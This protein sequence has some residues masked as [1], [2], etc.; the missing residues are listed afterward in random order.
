MAN[1]FG[2]SI[3]DGRAYA[4]HNAQPAHDLSP[5]NSA[6]HLCPIPKAHAMQVVAGA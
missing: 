1:I 2:E 6:Q 4:L 3:A 5:V